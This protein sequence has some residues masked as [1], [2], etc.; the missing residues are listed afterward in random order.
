MAHSPSLRVLLAEDSTLLAF[1]LTELIRRLPDVELIGTVDCEADT[2]SHVAADTPDVLILDL[3]L[4]S[5]SGFGVLRALSRSGSSRD[6][7]R[8][9][10]VILTNFGLPEYRREAEAFGVEAF[11][12][13]SRDYFRLPSL[14]TDFAR[15]R[16]EKPH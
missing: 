9:K 12:D 2:L 3:H 11:L 1:R 15:D 8:P 4:R 14:L 10:I 16:A 5:G 6:H 7:P 13:K